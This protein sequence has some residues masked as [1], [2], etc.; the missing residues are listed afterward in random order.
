MW[1]YSTGNKRGKK[2]LTLRSYDL[3]NKHKRISNTKCD[4]T[5]EGDYE[6]MEGKNV[7]YYSEMQ[8]LFAIVM[9]WMAS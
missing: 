8:T 1:R 2:F 7:L 4:N 6:F 5:K 9:H 3:W